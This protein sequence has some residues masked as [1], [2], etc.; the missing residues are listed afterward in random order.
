MIL[1]ILASLLV[2]LQGSL[3]TRATSLFLFFG[4]LIRIYRAQNRLLSPII[5][6]NL[7]IILVN[8]QRVS[9]VLPCFG[10]LILL[11]QEPL[12]SFSKPREGD[13][14]NRAVPSLEG[15][16]E[17]IRIIFIEHCAH[18]FLLDIAYKGLEL[19]AGVVFIEGFIGSM[20]ELF[21]HG[22]M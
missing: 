18:C 16:D 4:Y 15:L 7:L 19:V 9:G 3:H 14:S 2:K 21:L 11:Y 12:K 17:L 6:L 8:F 13:L 10:G 20:E 5:L 22:F 1:P